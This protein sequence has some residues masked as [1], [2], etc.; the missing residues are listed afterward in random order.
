M[1]EAVHEAGHAGVARLL[2][3]P[4][5]RTALAGVTTRYRRGDTKAHRQQ[6]IIALAGPCVEDR[7]TGYTPEQRAPVWET[8][9]REDL[10]NAMRHLD[11]SG[12]GMM[13]PVKRAAERLVR[14]HWNAIER[15]AKAL[16]ERGQL[17]AAEVDALLGT[18]RR[19]GMSALP[20][21]VQLVTATLLVVYRQ[22]FQSPRSS[23]VVD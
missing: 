5:K 21:R 8:A 6:A 3:Q 16:H 11:A 20:L 9:W 19:C 1:I 12:G 15:V 7:H 4:V 13:A 23:A 22:G 2:A 17:N 14:E 10:F 18:D